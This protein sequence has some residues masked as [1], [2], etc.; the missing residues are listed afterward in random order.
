MFWK[1]NKRGMGFIL[2]REEQVDL[3]H[4]GRFGFGRSANSHQQISMSNSIFHPRGA[5]PLIQGA[6]FLGRAGIQVDSLANGACGR[7]VPAADAWIEEPV[8]GSWM[9]ECLSEIVLQRML[10]LHELATS[11]YNLSIWCGQFLDG[12]PVW[13]LNIVTRNTCHNSVLCC[14][15]RRMSH[16]LCFL[17][18]TWP[19][20]S[21]MVKN[22]AFS[23][24]THAMN[25]QDSGPVYILYIYIMYI[26]VCIPIYVIC[27]FCLYMY[28]DTVHVYSPF[29]AF[30]DRGSRSWKGFPWSWPCWN[31]VEKHVQEGFFPPKKSYSVVGLLGVW[32]F[33]KSRKTS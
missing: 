7:D 27:T 32:N 21:K 11:F 20:W 12:V 22:N 25:M 4:I 18:A 17:R 23:F 14:H 6:F 2:L 26:Y 5:T 31:P 8:L 29:R 24:W 13:G 15:C 16:L 19:K 10:R 28:R 1:S 30:G 9:G 33:I 3:H